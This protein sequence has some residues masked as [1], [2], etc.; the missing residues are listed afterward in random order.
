MYIFSVPK[1]RR[2]N[3]TVNRRRAGR[4]VVRVVRS[5]PYASAHIQFEPARSI[6][7]TD[8]Q[9]TLQSRVSLSPTLTSHSCIKKSLTIFAPRFCLREKPNA[10]SESWNSHLPICGQQDPKLLRLS[11]KK[12]FLEW[13]KLRKRNS[14]ILVCLDLTK[15][16]NGTEPD[17]TFLGR[18]YL[19]SEKNR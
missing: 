18:G 15:S 14:R 17:E 10:N 12:G 4:T 8:H 16:P 7:F 11:T 6:I 1:E 2:K 19:R 3:P 9:Y 5:K 13:I